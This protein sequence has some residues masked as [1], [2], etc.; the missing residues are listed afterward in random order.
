M[1]SQ[2]INAVPA[3]NNPRNTYRFIIP[4]KRQSKTT[5]GQKNKPVRM[6]TCTPL[7]LRYRTSD[8]IPSSPIRRV[9]DS[10]SELT[11]TLSSDDGNIT[12][13]NVG[14]GA[15]STSK[16]K[17]LNITKPEEESP[18][19]CN[20]K[21]FVSA[22]NHLDSL[23]SFRKRASSLPLPRKLIMDGTMKDLNRS[24]SCG[25]LMELDVVVGGSIQEP[26]D[27]VVGVSIHDPAA[28]GTAQVIQTNGSDKA[29]VVVG[30]SIQEPTDVS[31]GLSIQDP[32]ASTTQVDQ[33]NDIAI[34]DV[35]V[36]VSI[37]E[38][39][40]VDTV[41]VD[42]ANGCDALDQE[43]S[44]EDNQRMI[45]MMN[46]KMANKLYPIFRRKDKWERGVILRRNAVG[47]PNRS[48]P[49]KRK[50]PPSEIN[51]SI[52]WDE[53]P[54]LRSIR[55]NTVGSPN[56]LSRKPVRKRT[57]SLA[58]VDPRQSLI[59]DLMSSNKCQGTSAQE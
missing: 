50:I 34:A 21:T 46:E 3:H 17:G 1:S 23:E 7:K 40:A 54:R 51:Q 49:V 24:K 25:D 20:A 55:R 10:L 16:M 33:T 37:Q 13:H 43:F 18:V 41:Q 15:D 30:V 32:A 2:L 58:T 44:A 48:N 12:N 28:T 22:H 14:T 19:T 9:D 38:P 52:K 36:E 39:A 31:V 56:D 45:A 59:T 6:E 42:Q 4:I 29:G 11:L 8:D 5:L 57:K 27:V 26:T 53:S 47:H 35:V